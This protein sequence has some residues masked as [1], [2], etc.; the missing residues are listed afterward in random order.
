MGRNARRSGSHTHLTPPVVIVPQ[1]ISFFAS[2]PRWVLKN[3]Q[4]K[5]FP[6]L[7]NLRKKT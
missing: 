3:A 1:K 4:S 5:N 7:K 6:A 2:L